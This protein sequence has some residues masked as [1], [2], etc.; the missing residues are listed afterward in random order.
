[1]LKYPPGSLSRRREDAFCF[2]DW[3]FFVTL[4]KL[5]ANQ[6]A[7]PQAFRKSH[8]GSCSPLCSSGNP[9]LRRASTVHPAMYPVSARG[10]T[11]TRI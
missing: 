11:Q 1:M 2:V 4:T 7:V 10:R 3:T 5:G 8:P 9:E 6:A